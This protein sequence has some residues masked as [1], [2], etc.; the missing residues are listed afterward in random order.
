MPWPV[1]AGVFFVAVVLL[2]FLRCRVIV[3]WSSEILLSPRRYP[4]QTRA[5][6]TAVS[7]R[8]CFAMEILP[9]RATSPL[10]E[11]GQRD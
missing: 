8:M 9:F 4:P 2:R 11:L 3:G 7:M 6:V 5:N 1:L 10:L